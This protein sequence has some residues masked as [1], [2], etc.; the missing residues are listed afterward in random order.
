MTNV[1]KCHPSATA[2]PAT[3][4]KAPKSAI[5]NGVDTAKLSATIGAIKADASLAH[6]QFRLSNQWVGG[7]ENR[8]RID[9]FHGAGQEMRHKQPFFLVSD[10]PEVLLSDDRGPNAGE[11]VLHALASCLTGALV[12]HAAARGIT[13]KGIAT[14]LEG[15][16]DLQG[17]L[18]LSKDVRRG[19]EN[20]RVTFDI[21]ADCD[22]SGKQELIEMAQAYSPVFDMLTN[23]LPVS[24]RLGNGEKEAEAV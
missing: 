14:R 15:D 9:D 13:V 22:D 23:G 16:I 1:I 7:G 4:L 11:Y 17:F 6:F 12:Y 2:K 5:V 18:G 21:D 3:D 10:E 8:S 24:C 19:F 20:I